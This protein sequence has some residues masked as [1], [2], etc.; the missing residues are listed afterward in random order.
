MEIHISLKC[1]LN[2]LTESV[3][4]EAL[5][6]LCCFA[7]RIL[8]VLKFH[9]YFPSYDHYCVPQDIQYNNYTSSLV[10]HS[11]FVT[12]EGCPQHW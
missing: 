3:F 11:K 10:L 9:E 7:L 5:S 2:D 6:A 8:N 4:R 12:K 1:H